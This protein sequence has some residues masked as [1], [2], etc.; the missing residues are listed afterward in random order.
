VVCGV[1]GIVRGADLNIDAP[2][3]FAPALKTTWFFPPG[4]QYDHIAGIFAFFT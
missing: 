4:S 1:A 2:T 3:E